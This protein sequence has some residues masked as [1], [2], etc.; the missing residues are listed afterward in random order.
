MFLCVNNLALHV[1]KFTS[2]ASMPRVGFGKIVTV[3]PVG[4]FS[5]NGCGW[6]LLLNAAWSLFAPD[7]SELLGTYESVPGVV[8]LGVL[9]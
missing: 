1:V 3:C 5:L 4:S 2:T 6:S 8:L 9:G 7:K